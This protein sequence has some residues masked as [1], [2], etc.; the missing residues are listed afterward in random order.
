MGKDPKDG[1]K[2]KEPTPIAQQPPPYG[3]YNIPSYSFDYRF[4]PHQK[5]EK[6]SDGFFKKFKG[7][8][9]MQ[10]QAM[11]GFT[12]LVGLRD[13]NNLLHPGQ[14]PK[15]LKLKKKPTQQQQDYQQPTYQTSYTSLQYPH[16]PNYEH[17]YAPPPEAPAYAPA[18]DYVPAPVYEQAPEPAYALAPEPAPVYVPEQA[19]VYAPAPEPAPVYAPPPVD[20]PAPPPNE[21]PTQHSATDDFTNTVPMFAPPLWGI[22]HQARAQPWNDSSA[23]QPDVSSL[24]LQEPKS[25]T[26]PVAV[27]HSLP[28]Q[29]PSTFISIQTNG[30]LPIFP[31][32]VDPLP[33]MPS[34]T[35]EQTEQWPKPTGDV[36]SFGVAPSSLSSPPPRSSRFEESE[37]IDPTVFVSAMSDSQISEPLDD[38]EDDELTQSDAGGSLSPAEQWATPCVSENTTSM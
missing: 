17:S 26:V 35:H 21:L 10:A 25:E 29:A 20:V 32:P 4:P 5:P 9:E 11:K 36:P 33:F 15:K 18:P 23:P 6:G 7:I 30:F 3:S 14:K 38:N 24:E 22:P 12:R 37:P 1:G 19:P 2:M 31:S 28:T 8:K 34:S 13:L 27:F 16:Q